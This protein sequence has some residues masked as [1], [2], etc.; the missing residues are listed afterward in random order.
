MTK[1]MSAA[2]AAA[3]LPLALA[4]GCAQS[5]PERDARPEPT[6]WQDV[7]PITVSKCAGCH[8]EGGIAPFPLDDYAST[9][10]RA[11]AIDDAVRSGHM[12]PFLLARDGTCGDFEDDAALTAEELDVIHRWATGARAEGTPVDIARP[13]IP[14]LEG[15]IEY[16][17]P[18][19][20]PI[21]DPSNPLGAEDE[22]RCFAM[23]PGIPGER[24]I[25]G[26]QVTP[27]EP[28]IVHHVTVFVVNPSAASDIEGKTNGDLMAEY[29]DASPDRD[30]W[31]CFGAAGEG[32]RLESY[33][34]TWAP[35]QVVV[36][37]PGGAG[38]PVAPSDRLVVQVHYNLH[39]QK[40]PGVMDSTRIR[41]R[42]AETV[43]RRAF[44]LSS[45]LFLMSLFRP[46]GPDTLPP[47]QAAA[48]YTWKETRTALGVDPALPPLEVLGVMP[49]MHERGRTLELR[50]ESEER[51]ECIARVDDWDM[52][53]QQ[54]YW[55]RTPRVLSESSSLELTCVYDTS[56]DSSPV[57]PGWGTGNEMCTAVLL[58]ALPEEQ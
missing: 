15:A 46:E 19:I 37:Y 42:Y 2:R 51:D 29:D 54:L 53:W 43:K 12:P 10:A 6:F 14:S 18:L 40:A 9:K 58:L 23:D 27:G 39:H 48:A 57:L 5:E 33:P 56:G 30:G 4:L 50:L 31:D 44:P 21:I 24:F 17:T 1:L 45:D 52:H 34:V 7:A 11:G 35:G 22:Y 41:L 36:E 3:L 47:G 26:Y 25:T 13:E 28:S 16:E 49:H 20:A 55:Y 8:Q 32:I 38:I